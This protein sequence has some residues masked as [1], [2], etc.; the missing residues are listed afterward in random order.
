[1]GILRNNNVSKQ[2]NSNTIDI[3]FDKFNLINDGEIIK[4]IKAITD[5]FTSGYLYIINY[6][7]NAQI[8]Y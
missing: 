4:A 3:V 1:L 7:K 2:P 5:D 8:K 6:S